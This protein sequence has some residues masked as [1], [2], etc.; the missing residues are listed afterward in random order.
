MALVKLLSW[1]MTRTDATTSVACLNLDFGLYH[2]GSSLI[3]CLYMYMQLIFGR[4][5]ALSVF[6][7]IRRRD[8]VGLVELFFSYLRRLEQKLH[9]TVVCL[10]LTEHKATYVRLQRPDLFMNR[11]AIKFLILRRAS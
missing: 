4:S 11:P 8:N 5:T 7:R 3:V 1:V 10:R 2:R 9:S 6:A